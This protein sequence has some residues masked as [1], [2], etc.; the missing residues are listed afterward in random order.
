MRGHGFNKASMGAAAVFIFLLLNGQTIFAQSELE[1]A[2]ELVRK[3]KARESENGFCSKVAWNG[4]DRESYVRWLEGA[5][6]GT[7]KVNKWANGNCQFDEVT[8]ISSRDGRKC[9]HYTWHTCVPGGECGMGS[10]IECKQ[11]DGAWRR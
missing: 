6:N 5:T 7:T 2:V 1:L 4:L 11:S 9:V 10:D 3:A 8:Q